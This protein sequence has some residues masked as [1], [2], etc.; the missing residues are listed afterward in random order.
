[1]QVS[2]KHT[3]VEP[4]DSMCNR[5]RTSSP[6][7]ADCSLTNKHAENIEM[8]CDILCMEDLLCGLL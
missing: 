3:F 1:M 7:F 8:F 2:A 5:L 4:D 6:M